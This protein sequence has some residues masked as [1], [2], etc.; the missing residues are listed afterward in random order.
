M[1]P[2]EA[3]ISSFKAALQL[4]VPDGGK[5]LKLGADTEIMSFFA[6]QRKLNIA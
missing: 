5:V 4:R 3:R 1:L 6:A 2:D